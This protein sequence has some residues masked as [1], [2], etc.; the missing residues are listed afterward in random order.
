M[1]YYY[2]LQIRTDESDGLTMKFDSWDDMCSTANDMIWHST[3][4][5]LVVIKK[6]EK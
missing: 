2:L 6:V 4:P 5:V 3:E 1:N